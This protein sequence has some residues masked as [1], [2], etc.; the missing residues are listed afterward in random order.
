[1]IELIKNNDLREKLSNTAKYE[2]K[3]YNENRYYEN[4]YQLLINQKG[5]DLVK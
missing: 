4:Y 1:M 3:E 2:I 5:C